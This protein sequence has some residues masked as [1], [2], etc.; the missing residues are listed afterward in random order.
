MAGIIV[1]GWVHKNEILDS[2]KYRHPQSQIVAKLFHGAY[3]KFDLFKMFG[4][5]KIFEFKIL[6]VDPK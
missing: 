5:D 3:E 6:T 4:V 2:S 1:S